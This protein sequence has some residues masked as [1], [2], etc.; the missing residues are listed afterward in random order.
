MDVTDILLRLAGAFYVFAGSVATRAGLMS[1]FLDTAIAQLGAKPVPRVE[2]HRTAW[3]LLSAGFV[4]AGGLALVFLMQAALPLF[5]L[6]AA[7]QAAYLTLIGPRYFDCA[8]PPDPAG[9]RQTTHAFVLYLVAT[10]FVAWGYAAGK[11]AAFDQTPQ[12]ALVVAASAMVAHVGYVM[13]SLA[14]PKGGRSAGSTMASAGGDAAG[15]PQDEWNPAL[16][17]RVK[18]MADYGCYPLWALDD[19][20]YV[21]FHPDALGLSPELTGELSAWG[22]AYS[23][24]LDAD[25]LS[26]SLWS[27]ERHRQ[28]D[29]EGRR[30]AERLATE[31]PDLMVYVLE[32]E[33]GLVEVHA[34]EQEGSDGG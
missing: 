33:T 26:R 3:L 5:L 34:P 24:S 9:R 11:L 30:L 19:G 13:R 6:S 10:A 14:G 15:G 22:E 25:N 31:R 7:G 2:L 1:H 32:P 28:H 20:R 4:L 21:N 12:W 27:E 17:I 16:A 29:V 23:S 8:D 18:V